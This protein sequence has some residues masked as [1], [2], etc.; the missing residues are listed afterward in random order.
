ML[1]LNVVTRSFGELVGPLDMNQ[2]A[3]L[4]FLV[5]SRAVFLLS[6]QETA[7]LLL[8]PLVAGVGALV[9]FADTAWKAL[10]KVEAIAVLI[11]VAI[12]T[13]GIYFSGEF[14]QYSSEVLVNCGIL[15]LAIKTED[16]TLNRGTMLLVAIVTVLAPLFSFSSFSSLPVFLAFLLAK[17]LA[18]RMKLREV[19]PFLL[20]FS[21]LAGAYWFL[22]RPLGNADLTQYHRG[23]FPPRGFFEAAR[24]WSGNWLE[25]FS[26]PLNADYRLIVPLVLPLF[27]LFL[28]KPTQG[29][30]WRW[31]AL[32]VI[33]A[34]MTATQLHLYP[35]Y[36]GQHDVNARFVVQLGPFVLLL[37]GL[38]M[39][40]LRQRSATEWVYWPIVFLFVV[41]VL[42]HRVSARDYLWQDLP[43]AVAHVRE[44]AQQN[45]CIWVYSAAVPQVNLATIDV[46][47]PFTVGVAAV[48][49][50]QSRFRDD[51]MGLQR[52]STMWLI[53]GH[54]FFGDLDKIEQ[55]ARSLGFA[56]E[57]S[58]FPGAAVFKATRR[59]PSGI[60][61]SPQR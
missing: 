58:R 61:A 33:L 1:A 3:P 10:P 60:G 53:V 26:Y 20:L 14:K 23:G 55:A 34:S 18:R 51:L 32:A 40:N 31:F 15:W 11:P 35:F 46:D 6:N 56:V 59:E 41:A 17:C 45:D 38:G 9:V 5:A 13:T 8:V 43:S 21:Y 25:F 30:T 28:L 57:V 27:G 47:F 24:W 19:A 39:A 16:S 42:S 48:G 29:P 22:I 50:S 37:S 44:H 54:D 4:G 36:A 52:C 7:W 49:S 12:G 2:A